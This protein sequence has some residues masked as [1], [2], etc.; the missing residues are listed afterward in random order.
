M[1]YS[2]FTAST[3]DWTPAEAASILAAQGWDGIEWRVTDQAEATPPGFWA[4]N[5]ATW[6]LTGLEDHLDEIREI[7]TSNGLAFSGIGG[8]ALVG[9][10]SDAERMLAA[11]AA[12]GATQVRI[13]MPRVDGQ[14]YVELFAQARADLEHIVTLAEKYGVKAL[15][16]LHHETITPSASA[17]RRLVEGLNPA[18]VGVIHDVG[19]LINEGFENHLAG[20]QL[21]GEYLAHVHIKNA[22]WVIDRVEIDGTHVWRHEWTT[23]RAGQADLAAYVRDLVAFGYDGWITLEDFSTEVPLEQRTAENLAYVRSLV[24]SAQG[25]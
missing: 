25:V 3:P 6:P 12:V 7:T 8:Y 21:L 2:V 15:V 16:E 17:A 13:T 19:N 22:Q 20:F 1:K 4:G 24:E 18:A 10:H 23:L 14:N 11:T 5:R 9:N